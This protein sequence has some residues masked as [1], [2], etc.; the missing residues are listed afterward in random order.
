MIKVWT[1]PSPSPCEIVEFSI[2][3]TVGPA[4]AVGWSVV[5]IVEASST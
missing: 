3:V 5:L 1:Y 2:E 4:S